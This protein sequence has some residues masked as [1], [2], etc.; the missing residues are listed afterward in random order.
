LKRKLGIYDEVAYSYRLM[1]RL[2]QELPS[3]YLV[4]SFSEEESFK[5][6]LE[7]ENPDIL[8]VGEIFYS[9]DL[10]AYDKGKLI[11]LTESNENNSENSIYKYQ[12]VSCIARQ[13]NSICGNETK[14]IEKTN[15]GV[16][17]V[18]V[19]SPLRRCGKTSLA[20]A[21]S[22]V[23]SRKEK[24][25]YL[26]FEAFPTTCLFEKNK[27]VWNLSDVFYF[28]EQNREMDEIMQNAITDY[29]GISV[30]L[31][32][33]VPMD[34]QEISE[35][36]WEQFFLMISD[37]KP[38][39]VVVIDF[40]ESLSCYIQLL[41]L[42]DILYSP[43]LHDGTSEEKLKQFNDFLAKSGLDSIKDKIVTLD[44]KI[45]ELQ[46]SVSYEQMVEQLVER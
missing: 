4:Y 15:D 13:L 19:Y 42:C 1:Q 7:K 34:L 44:F 11:I 36:K 31:P 46:N 43:I 10:T 22:K 20:V 12:P 41:E 9:E 35:E 28:M 33:E 6:F 23:Y 37:S 45:P 30:I 24:V 14:T 21:L 29:N 27:D 5:E 2:N 26:N 18:G 8:L 16:R 38:A 40:D 25:L 3:G 17:F 32:A 39:D